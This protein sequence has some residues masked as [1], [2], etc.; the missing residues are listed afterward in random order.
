LYG[1]AGS[2][3]LVQ[4][5]RKNRTPYIQHEY[6]ISLNGDGRYSQVAKKGVGDIPIGI[7]ALRTMC[8]VL[9]EADEN[10]NLDEIE[11]QLGVAV[12]PFMEPLKFYKPYEIVSGAIFS[13]ESTTFEEK[14]PTVR[15]LVKIWGK[16]GEQLGKYVFGH[17]CNDPPPL[18]AQ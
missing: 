3:T 12:A 5:E 10:T 14:D 8:S 17:F 15:Y 7:D 11:E 4:F 1:A 18:S 6:T 2:N 16:A 9:S 13:G